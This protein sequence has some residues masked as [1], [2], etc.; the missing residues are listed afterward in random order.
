MSAIVAFLWHRRPQFPLPSLRDKLLRVFPGTQFCPGWSWQGHV[1]SL[2]RAGG[3][4]RRYSPRLDTLKGPSYG[5]SYLFHLEEAFGAPFPPRD[6]A[7]QP[8]T[9]WF[10]AWR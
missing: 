5:M 8:L 1:V 10:P 7:D 4:G 3:E 2:S 9:T 6:S